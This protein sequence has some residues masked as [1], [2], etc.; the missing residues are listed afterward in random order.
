MDNATKKLQLIDWIKRN[1]KY[2]D[3]VYIDKSLACLEQRLQKFS[4][5]K[6]EDIATFIQRGHSLDPLC[7]NRPHKFPN[8]YFR[9]LH[10]LD[11]IES[12]PFLHSALAYQE[13]TSNELEIVINGGYDDFMYR[14]YAHNIS[15][16]LRKLLYKCLIQGVNLTHDFDYR[17]YMDYEGINYVNAVM[18][19]NDKNLSFHIL[20]HFHT[21]EYCKLKNLLSKGITVNDIYDK[22]NSKEIT[23]GLLMFKYVSECE[24]HGLDIREYF[25]YLTTYTEQHSDTFFTIVK[26]TNGNLIPDATTKIGAY[27]EYIRYIGGTILLD[28]ASEGC[29]Y[30]LELLVLI[31]IQLELGINTEPYFEYVNLLE[32]KSLVSIANG[33]DLLPY[34]VMGIEEP[35]SDIFDT[36]YRKHKNA[37]MDYLVG[38]KILR[39]SRNIR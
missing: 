9:L 25:K 23:S 17:L 32:W 14:E 16:E 26:A 5:A 28:W 18:R 22:F 19:G 37:N 24:S 13:D 21:S 29:D 8:S 34:L 39:Q 38:F 33:E 36:Y 7:S 35:L 27:D 20:R 3:G 15:S 6:V 4:L 11:N 1:I 30:C 31:E 2:K 12:Y 10:K